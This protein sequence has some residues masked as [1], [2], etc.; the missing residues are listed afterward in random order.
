MTSHENCS[1]RICAPS[2]SFAP[3][4]SLAHG[5]TD[6]ADG[7]ARALLGVGESAALGQAASCRSRSSSRRAGRRWSTSCLRHVHDGD[8]S[9]DTGRNRRQAADLAIGSRRIGG[10]NDRRARGIARGPR[11]CPGTDHQEVAAEARDLALHRRRSR[12]CPSVTIAITAATPITMP[13]MVR[14]ERSTLRR[15]ARSAIEERVAEHQRATLVVRSSLST[16]PS[17]KRT[18]RRAYAAMSGSCV[19]ITIGDAVLAV[20]RDDQQS[21][22][23]RL[24]ARVEVAGRL[25]GEQ[26]RRPRDDRARDRDALLLSA[27]QLGRRM[28][29]P[30]APARPTR[31]P[32]A[33]LRG[34]SARWL[35]AIEQ[36]QLDV[37]ERGGARQQVEALEDEAE[38]VP[39]QQRA[40]VARQAFRRRRREIGTRRSSACRGSRGCSWRSTCRSRSAP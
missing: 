20:E 3:N 17:T 27:G 12:R 18:M 25:V 24:R 36:R 11:R 21:M 34:A 4:S 10:A 16:R 9:S 2:G 35:A 7:G 19:T 26:H 32:R 14:N 39:A 37:L 40:L 30:S 15:I 31:A 6:D 28:V 8:A 1:I 29:L 5:F 23:S 13:S 38:I 22:I 33:R